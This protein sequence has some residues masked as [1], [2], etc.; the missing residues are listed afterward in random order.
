MRYVENFLCEFDIIYCIYHDNIIYHILL[1]RYILVKKKIKI[2][3]DKV[4]F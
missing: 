4:E 2:F 1:L 3:I